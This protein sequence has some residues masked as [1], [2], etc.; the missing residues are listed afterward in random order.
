MKGA[1]AHEA[2]FRSMFRAKGTEGTE[3]QAGDLAP[4]PATAVTLPMLPLTSPL[5]PG[6][7]HPA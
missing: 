6:T 1:E 5:L 4:V 7:E 2:P 3:G